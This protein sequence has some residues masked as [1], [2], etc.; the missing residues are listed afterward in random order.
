[1]RPE[2]T[3]D[4]MP[5]SRRLVDFLSPDWKVLVTFIPFSLLAAG[6][7]AAPS[8][9]LFPLLPVGGL[10]YLFLSYVVGGIAFV[11]QLGPEYYSF[12]GDFLTIL[13]ATGTA[14][15]YFLSF[16]I[17]YVW[18]RS[19]D[20]PRQM[21]ITSLAAI[22]ISPFLLLYLPAVLFPFQPA[23]QPV[24]PV[25][26]ETCSTLLVANG[27]ARW[28]QQT[29]TCT[30]N[31]ILLPSTDH[32]LKVGN[33]TS[34]EISGADS[35]LEYS[36][37]YALENEGVISLTRGATFVNVLDL[38]DPENP[39][40]ALFMNKGGLMTDDESTIINDGRIDL[41]EL[42]GRIVNNGLLENRGEIISNGAIENNGLMVN[43]GYVTI[44]NTDATVEA[45]KEA[46]IQNRGK[47]ENL[48]SFDNSGGIFYNYIPGNVENYGKLQVG[49]L[50]N[51]SIL[52]NVSGSLTGE[53]VHNHCG[54]KVLGAI[55]V[56]VEFSCYR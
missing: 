19:N 44:Y 33:G 21:M 50:H 20:R 17:S 42:T 14:Y 22:F 24:V 8:A 29:M 3:H 9:F 46:T 38:G 11:F 37:F 25:T 15:L 13:A 34:L 55:V 41:V 28:N 30:V 4:H 51:Y 54:G 16:Y 5:F 35:R 6:F 32:V 53:I 31:G 1:M 40:Q 39:R 27:S 47:I 18:K 2:H 52:E 43:S 45:G 56:P 48:A 26:S 10:Y 36:G 49:V 12:G 7:F 23:D